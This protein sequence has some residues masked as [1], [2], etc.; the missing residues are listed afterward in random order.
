MTALSPS[1]RRVTVAQW[2][3]LH[4]A[5]PRVRCSSAR[6]RLV[7]LAALVLLLSSATVSQALQLRGRRIETITETRD[8]SGAVESF[9]FLSSD[10]AA[11]LEVSRQQLLNDTELDLSRNRLTRVPASLFQSMPNVK[12]VVLSRNPIRSFESGSFVGLEMLEEIIM[13]RS[14]LAAFPTKFIHHCPRLRVVSFNSSFVRTIPSGA[15]ANLPMLEM[16]DLSHNNVTELFDDSFRDLASIHTLDLSFNNLS[17]V[18]S[19]VFRVS[20]GWRKLDFSRN[21]I[22]KA[23]TGLKDAIVSGW[24]SFEGNVWVEIDAMEFAGAS[25]IRALILSSMGIFT[26]NNKAFFGMTSLEKLDLGDNVISMLGEDA[27]AGLPSLKQL[28]LRENNIRSAV[29]QS[30]PPTM[31]KLDLAFNYLDSVPTLLGDVNASTLKTLNLSHNWIWHLESGSQF[32]PYT[33]L[34]ELDVSWNR[35]VNFTASVFDPINDTIHVIHLDYNEIASVPRTTFLALYQHNRTSVTLEMNPGIG[36]TPDVRERSICPSGSVFEMINYTIDASGAS[37]ATDGNASRVLFG[38]IQCGIGSFHDNV[39][40]TCKACHDVSSRAYT[41]IDGATSCQYCPYSSDLHMNREKCNAFVCNSYCWVTIVLGIFFPLFIMGGRCVLVASARLT[42]S[43]NTWRAAD[44]D[45][46][47]MDD[48][49]IEELV[50]HVQTTHGRDD[51]GDGNSSPPKLFDLPADAQTTVLETL[52]DYFLRRRAKRRATTTSSADLNNDPSA[53]GSRPRGDRERERDATVDAVAADVAKPHNAP[54]ARWDQMEWDSFNMSRILSRNYHGE[55][56]LGDADGTSVVVKRMM[57]LRFDVRELSDVLREVDLQLSLQ[58]PRLVRWLG[59]FWHDAD[60]FCAI[61]EYV[62]AGDLHAL[63]ELETTT[64][65]TRHPPAT[66]SGRVV[67]L[68]E[69]VSSETTTAQP[70]VAELRR[71]SMKVQLMLDV[72]HALAYLHGQ[73]VCHRDLRSRNVLISAEFRAKLTD[74]RRTTNTKYL[75]TSF[76]LLAVGGARDDNASRGTRAS[77]RSIDVG[78]LRVPLIAPEVVAKPDEFRPSADIY[79]C[80]ILMAE[81]WCHRLLAFSS[82]AQMNG[83]T[84]SVRE[85]TT[86][87]LTF[88]LS[89][90]SLLP[91]TLGDPFRRDDERIRRFISSLRAAALE[92]E[93]DDNPTNSQVSALGTTTAPRDAETASMVLKKVFEIMEECLQRDPLKRPTAEM[94]IAKFEQLLAA[95]TTTATAT[96]IVPAVASRPELGR[97]EITHI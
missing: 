91:L 65:L 27:L 72:L 19:G 97:G 61:C 31:E 34:V 14:N 81:M 54:D 17:T 9:Q 51:D 87:Q 20:L 92:D 44:D 68:K 60:Y 85:A 55:V 84:T 50:R 69:E 36:T 33:H 86:S 52:R 46:D 57:T 5:R 76:H 73:G 32:F 3:P 30:F 43:P 88:S 70:D 38:C 48:W 45:D 22:S 7:L 94:L 47:E 66:S 21:N 63:L 10:A 78:P 35:L 96:S 4:G 2:T 8:A 41:S 56:F 95:V 26:V 83:A 64:A 18:P 82:A 77:R 12:R 80:G 90:S 53:T 23:P 75:S 71:P 1:L 49:I 6:C 11:A 58:H 28:S 79:S 13:E 59:T 37:A 67:L 29:F 89:S 42:K 39:T 40:N 74:L 93:D 25:Q 16:I 15:L 62:P 24:V